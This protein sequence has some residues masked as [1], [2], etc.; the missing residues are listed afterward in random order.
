MHNF[1]TD[2]P[3]R[4]QRYI[5]IGI[6]AA[7]IYL[8]G[9]SFFG[10]VL[11]LSLGV[12]STVLYLGFTKHLWKW[13]WL[14]RRGLVAVPNL[15]GTWEGHLYTSADAGPIPDEQ[16]VR[17]E[18]Q[19]DGLTKQEAS[20]EIEQTWDKIRVSLDGPESPSHSRGATILIQEKASPT[21]SYNYWNDGSMTNDDL[22]PHYGTAILE[23][24]EDEDKLRGKYYNRPDQRGTHGIMELYRVN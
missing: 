7:V 9:T 13:G 20:L 24:N 3:N 12:V 14:H 21:L 6:L 4:H 16:I 15:N 5:L 22:D 18:P 17:E 1:S 10:P 2:Q 8:R 19:I 23:Y 11:G